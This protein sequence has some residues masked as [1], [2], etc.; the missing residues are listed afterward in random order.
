MVRRFR[1]LALSVVAVV[2]VAACSSTTT[3]N[4][5]ELHSLIENELGPEI[6]LPVTDANCPEV[7]DPS[8]GTTFECTATV[9]GQ[10]LRIA[11]VVTDID[12]GF[13][14]VENADAILITEL[15]EQSIVDDVALELDFVVT[16][17]CA[18]T[19]VIVARPGSQVRCSVTDGI[20]EVTMVVEV[21]NAE[22]NVMYDFE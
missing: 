19:E 10:T 20:D 8:N 7:R 13:V 18:D 17:D 21:L 16:A 9:D 4:R 3:L 11:A 2:A 14:E 12:T 1:P 5:S 22:G 15:L 6:G